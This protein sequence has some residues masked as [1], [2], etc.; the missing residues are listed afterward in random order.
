MW[1]HSGLHKPRCKKCRHWRAVEDGLCFQCLSEERKAAL[2]AI[3][4]ASQVK[5]RIAS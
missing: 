2:D 3:R 1:R 4:S 5:R